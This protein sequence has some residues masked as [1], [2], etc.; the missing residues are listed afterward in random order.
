MMPPSPDG[1]AAAGLQFPLVRYV[2]APREKVFRMWSEPDHFR[3]WSAPTGFRIAHGDS[4]FRP[5]GAW[6]CHMVGPDGTEHRAC[7]LYLD[8]LAPEYIVM[9]H[10]WEDARGERS[11]ETHLD[12]NLDALGERTRLTLHQ[13]LFSSEVDCNGHQAGWSECLDALADQLHALAAQEKP[14]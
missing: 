8:I 5:G 9:S 4:D 3:R 12:V 2:D 11:P 14:R 10:R 6:R 7:G 13:G 1:D